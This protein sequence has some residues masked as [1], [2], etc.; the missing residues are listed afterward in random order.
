MNPLFVLGAGTSGLGA[1]LIGS[2][3]LFEAQS[4]P[5]GICRSLYSTTDSS[6]GPYRFEIG[7]GHWLFGVTDE[8]QAL[9]DSLVPSKVY[10]RKSA[11]YL[12]DRELYVPYPI[13][14]HLGWL[15]EDI[16]ERALQEIRTVRDFEASN[17]EDS[18]RHRFGDT[19]MELFFGPFH[20]LYTA[21]LYREIAPQD[22]YKSP[23]DIEK[24]IQGAKGVDSTVGYNVEFRYPVDGLD[25][26]VD[27]LAKRC[28]L[29]CNKK[30]VGIDTET[31]VISFGDG[32]EVNYDQ[33]IS[34]LPLNRMQELTGI[35]TE[36]RQDP[37][38]SVLVVNIGAVKGPKCPEHHWLYVPQSNSG[39]HRVGFYSNVDKS[40]VPDSSDGVDRVGIYVE[41]AYLG[42]S[43][44][45]REEIDRVSQAMV[46][47]LKDWGFIGEVEVLEPT[48]VDVA[49]TWRYPDSTWVETMI[50]KLKEKGIHQVGRYAE[51][52]F[53]GIIESIRAGMEAGR[54]LAGRR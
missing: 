35:E 25:A 13:Q 2:S 47:E 18:L 54:R 46:K 14:N 19:L 34:T 36:E 53:Q 29:R 40:F 24:V 22:G 43:K 7:G 11:V 49:Y 26:L 1:G 8:S 17:L 42:G 5:G 44:P 32:T 41:K 51:W 3:Y 21:G 33:V 10:Y 31:R 12:P 39:F 16:C 50:E 20:E 48:W 23:L 28:D 30:V 52:K 38:T 15:D 9:L 37:Y 27:A 4:Y 45:T 6:V